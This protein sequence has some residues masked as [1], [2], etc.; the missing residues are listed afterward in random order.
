M[1]P[2]DENVKSF[3]SLL[4]ET[5]KVKVDKRKLILEKLLVSMIDLYDAETRMVVNAMIEKKFI[6]EVNK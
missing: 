4:L 3:V 1:S 5:D 2:Y 6:P